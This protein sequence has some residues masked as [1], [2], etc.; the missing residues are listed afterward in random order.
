LLAFIEVSGE[1][2]H[3]R[4]RTSE[5]SVNF[6]GL[7]GATFQKTSIFVFASVRTCGLTNILLLEDRALVIML[8]EINPQKLQS[9]SLKESDDF[10][11]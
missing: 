11:Q 10:E 1:N 4:A 7:H 8:M 3:S 5:T 9:K 6:T 2:I